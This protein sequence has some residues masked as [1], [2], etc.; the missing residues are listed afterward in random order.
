MSVG[1]PRATLI[2]LLEGDLD[3][4]E[5]LCEAGLVP[6]EEEALLPEHAETARVVCTL[7]HELDINWPG[8]EVI[9]RMR[10]EIAATHRQVEDL[11]AL[12]REGG[13][14]R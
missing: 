4:F 7:V 6:R 9:I 14:G 13:G 11:L 1:M 3:L 8:V 12:L 2:E 5:R 10:S